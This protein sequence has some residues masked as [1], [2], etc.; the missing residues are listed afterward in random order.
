VAPVRSR[1][2]ALKP[3]TRKAPPPKPAAAS[4]LYAVV[5]STAEPSAAGAPEGPPG[6]GRLR[7]LSVGNGLWLAAADAPLPRYGSAAIEKGLK[8]LDWVSACAI[9]HERVVEH[10][11]RLGTVVPMKLFTLFSS[12][13]RAMADL[14]RSR[15]R[16][17][18]VLGRIEGRQEWGVRVSVDEA[19]ARTRAR[20]RAEQAAE[21]LSAGA[22]FLTRK[23]QE[24]K[25]VRD[26]LDLG[27]SAADD[28][29]AGLAPHADDTRRRPPSA[30]EPGLRLLLDA[31]FLVPMAR[32]DA[33]REAVRKQA[34]RLAPSGYR[35]V[36]TGPWPAY[37][38]V[39]GA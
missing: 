3:R 11:S 33:F 18:A 12:D 38:F 35:V 4:Y 31:A 19:T 6:M 7:W 2:A 13:A 39:A 9:A 14:G 37:N 16:L 28:V 10:V 22:R 36:L 30:A 8:D 27:R 34:E 20:E 5:A 24:H 1:R 26:I 17:R 23:G 29:F 21:G 25:E 15:T 32:A